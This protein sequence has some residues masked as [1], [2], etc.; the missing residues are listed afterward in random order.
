MGKLIKRIEAEIVESLEAG[1]AR[2]IKSWNAKIGILLTYN[3]ANKLLNRKEDLESEVKRY[4][5]YFHAKRN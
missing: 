4:S 1:E 2:N 5:N 3:E